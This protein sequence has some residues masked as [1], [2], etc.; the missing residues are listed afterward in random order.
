MMNQIVKKS[1]YA[2]SPYM[3]T[4]CKEVFE[5]RVKAQ[6]HILLA[7]GLQMADL[8]VSLQRRFIVEDRVL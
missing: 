8:E 5:N 7:L 3:C 1:E 6:K 4:T 2:E